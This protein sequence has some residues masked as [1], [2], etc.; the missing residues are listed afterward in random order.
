MRLGYQLPGVKTIPDQITQNRD[1]Y[2]EALEIADAADREGRIDV[3]AL[4]ALL[5]DMLAAQ[6][7]A[8]HESASGSPH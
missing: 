8:L 1:P 2:Y 3:S 5:G 6:L 4:E 7:V